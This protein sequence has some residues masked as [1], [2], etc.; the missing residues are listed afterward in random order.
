M[1]PALQTSS[2]RQRRTCRATPIHR[3]D[4]ALSWPFGFELLKAPLNIC[5]NTLVQIALLGIRKVISHILDLPLRG[6][7]VNQRTLVVRAQ[8]LP[9]V[10]VHAPTERSP[11]PQPRGEL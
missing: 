11:A 8:R 7:P 4:E 1:L 10:S 9:R 3:H 5:L 6:R 2:E